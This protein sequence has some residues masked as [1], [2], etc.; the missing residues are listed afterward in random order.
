MMTL[1]LGSFIP[2]IDEPPET[3]RLTT[4]NTYYMLYHTY[5]GWL[6]AKRNITLTNIP[7]F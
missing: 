1:L 2:D 5:P 4:V 6:T 3:M 7:K